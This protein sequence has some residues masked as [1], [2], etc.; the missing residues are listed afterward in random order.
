MIKLEHVNKYFYHHKKNEIHV[1]DD[2]SFELPSSG[3]IALLGPSGCGK[4]TLLNTIGGL[5]KVNSGNIYI[6][7][8]RITKRSQRYIDKVRN[9][10]IGYIFQDYNLIN[11]LS[12]FDNVALSLKMIGIKDKEEI[13]EKVNYVLEAV[14]IYRYRKR[15]AGMLSGGERQRVGIARAIVKDPSIIIADE[16]TG[17]LDSTNS[18]AI[19]NIIKSISKNRLVLLVTHETGLANFYAD[20]IMK[21]SDGKVV[22]DYINKPGENLDYRVD[23]K[24]YL[25]DFKYI[26]NL[27]DNN[28][29]IDVYSDD[30]K[31]LNIRI[32]VKN[33]NI[34]IES[35]DNK[36]EV[37]ENDSKVEIIDDHEKKID[38]SIYE[39]YEFDQDKLKNKHKPKYSSIVN[40]WRLIIDGFHKLLDYSIVKKLLLIGFLASAMFITYSICNIAGIK[41]ID[42]SQFIA[43]NRNYLITKNT[44]Y[45]VDDYL[46]IEKLDDVDYL[47]PSNG[48][49]TLQLNDFHYYQTHNVMLYL[50]GAVVSTDYLTKESLI[51]GRMPEEKYEIVIDKKAIDSLIKKDF[52]DSKMIGFSDAH[53]FLNHEVQIT[54]GIKF[55]IVGI[56]DLVEP[57]IFIDKDMINTALYYTISD[58]RFYMEGMNDD[59]LLDSSLFNIELS[60]GHLP[61]NDYEIVV[62]ENYQWQYP[63]NKTIDKKINDHKLKVVGYYKN[64]DFTNFVTNANT[65]KIDLISKQN[66][67]LIIMPKDAN[68][69]EQTLKEKNIILLSSY[70]AFKKQY[71]DAR[72]A[73]VSSGV[74]AALVML[75]ISFIEIYLMIRSSF[76][77]RV[78]EVGIYRAIGVKKT[79]IYKMFIGEILAIS[80]F[81]CIPGVLFMAY[82]LNALS[83][84]DY[85]A[86]NYLVNIVTI[87][88]SILF[89]YVFNLIIGLLPV[90]LVVKDTPA[91]ILSRK[92]LD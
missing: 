22:D 62:P 8:K 29:N 48:Q 39:E 30:K 74:I 77:S 18:I 17:N 60:K 84:I 20:R 28:N 50:T 34:Y 21:I 23:N 53:S 86:S 13:K 24:I 1:I 71:E 14:G 63:L 90:M 73:A 55:K 91:K 26:S 7:G 2:T 92:D 37:L 46:N 47:L 76:L 35:K 49:L 52:G 81:A 64:K 38:K 40:S 12:V 42:E 10:E 54:H 57:S 25:K 59:L 9:G 69:L 6:D 19:M 3:L 5:D 56:S 4:T 68:K 88:I 80:T 66:H 85:V 51:Y 31:K 11:D 16:P 83:T 65:I 89:I 44:R 70:E 32:I 87:S 82:C 61:E 43:M 72:A 45:S 67:D 15:P 41:K 58:G 27:N 36:V 78:K 33:N 75:V 79:D